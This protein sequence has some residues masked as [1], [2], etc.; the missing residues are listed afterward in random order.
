M[1]VKGKTMEEHLANLQVIFS[2]LEETSVKLKRSICSFSVLS[3]PQWYLGHKI[4]A[5]GV[6]IAGSLIR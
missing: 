3:V 6:H 5:A 4:S 2:R 1:L